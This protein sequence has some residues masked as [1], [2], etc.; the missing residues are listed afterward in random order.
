M[1][2]AQLIGSRNRSRRTA[3]LLAS[4]VWW[5]AASAW[6]QPIALEQYS[7]KV[8]ADVFQN[9][10][11]TLNF[12][13]GG[14]VNSGN[15]QATTLSAGS[16]FVLVR[17]H[18]GL[19][20][21]MDFAYGRARVT[22]DNV[23]RTVDTARNLRSRARYDVFLTPDDALFASAVY[24][25]DT[26][27]GL[28]ARVE[29]QFGYMRNFYRADAHR[30]WGELGYDLTYDNYDPDPLPDPTTPGAFLSGHE[31][32]HS[33]RAFLGYDNHLNAAVT[34]LTGFEALF[35]V[36]KAKDVRLNWDVALR[37]SL[38]SRLQLEVKFSLQFDNQ[39][40]PGKL[41]LDTQTRINLI[42]QL[43]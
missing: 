25:W 11:T 20:L 22:Q 16:N 6:A 33:V 12:S 32:V 43:I 18:N 28:D 3:A 34:F 7:Q 26:L 13:S 1:H 31:V 4:A 37:S 42:Y 19:Q 40:V 27:A 10:V 38:A 9:D 21:A 23:E 5:T 17:G 36:E 2:A 15:T 24:R 39:P 35:D 41:D 14:G 8:N 30:F 29:G